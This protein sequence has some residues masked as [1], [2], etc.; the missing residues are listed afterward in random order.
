M[1]MGA[2]SGEKNDGTGQTVMQ[3]GNKGESIPGGCCVQ[4]REEKM[5]KKRKRR[6]KKE[7]K[8]EVQW[9]RRCSAGEEGEGRRSW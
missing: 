7:R 4:V 9:V 8:G 3:G 6:N 5:G 2:A 1:E